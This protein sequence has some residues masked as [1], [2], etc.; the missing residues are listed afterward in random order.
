MTVKDVI[1]KGMKD[2]LVKDAQKSLVE[3]VTIDNSVIEMPAAGKNVLDFNG[4][5]YAGKVIVKNSTI[6]STGKNTGFFAQY[7]SRPKNVN[8]DLLQEFD[9]ENSTIVNIANGKNFCDLKQNGT[10][11]NVYTIKNNIFS[12]CGK[13]AGQVVVGFNKGQTSA[14]PVW[15]VEGN[16]FF[17]DGADVS[18]AETSKA[19]QKDGEDIV[20][21]SLTTDPEFVDAANGDFTV[22][23]ATEQAELET[24]DPRWLVPFD[25]GEVDNSALL[26]EIE[27]AK[28]LLGYDF[29]YYDKNTDDPGKALVDAI[30]S[31]E[32]V[33]ENATSQKKIDKA[34]E[35]L[36]EAEMTYANTVL[37]NEI[38]ESESLLALA[39]EDDD[40][41]KSL[42]EAVETAKGVLADD[43]SVPA[44][45]L[46]WANMLDNYQKEWLAAQLTEKVDEANSLLG[47]EEPKTETGKTLKEAAD[48]GQAEL[49]NPMN[50]SES[51][52]DAYVTLVAAL[53]A[54]KADPTAIRG[55]E[56]DETDAPVYN[57]AGQRVS[58]HAKG[59]VIKNG[60]KIIRK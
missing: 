35:S 21:N 28:K 50:T 39:D 38:A 1:I 4:K 37:E 34:V 51:L 32:D 42:A 26:S 53:E 5:G 46:A 14:T 36:K 19:G 16:T 10:A 23:E 20:K 13:A 49:D 40:L 8:G 57:M 3:T 41:A 52:T 25:G 58:S 18:E 54:Y 6:W 2:A 17:W 29:A 7:G 48:A 12:D 44:D 31:A 60:K 47:S 30:R 45:K 33:A 27:E 11:Q 22:G 15:D 59:I 9:F 43:T 56:A 55:I 24:G